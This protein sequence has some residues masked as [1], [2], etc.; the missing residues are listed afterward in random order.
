MSE[1]GPLYVV[2]AKAGTH[3]SSGGVLFRIGQSFPRDTRQERT[4]EWVPAFAGTTGE[5]A[6]CYAGHAGCRLHSTIAKV[7]C[8]WAPLT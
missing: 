4:A 3:R 5:S 7:R 6:Y 2:P 8:Q 1:I